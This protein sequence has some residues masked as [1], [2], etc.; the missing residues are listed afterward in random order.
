MDRPYRL[1][2]CFPML[3]VADV[4]EA[5]AFYRDKLG[6]EVVDDWTCGDPPFYG[7]IKLDGTILHFMTGE[8]VNKGFLIL[9]YV[10]NI[11]AFYDECVRRGAPVH[12]EP[13]AMDYGETQFTVTDCNGYD[14]C[15]TETTSEIEARG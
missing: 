15:F 8:V 13:K 1:N 4:R 3:H 14:I 2:H 6:F 10:I 5:Q 12:G 7:G 9:V 11:H